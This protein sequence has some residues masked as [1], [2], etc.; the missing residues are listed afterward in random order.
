MHCYIFFMQQ[1]A[2]FPITDTLPMGFA[3]CEE[4]LSVAAEAKLL[5]IISALPFH[6]A[7]YKEWSAKRRVIHYGGRYDFNKQQLL[8]A[9]TLPDWMLEL[10]LKIAQW[11][12]VPAEHFKQAL[13]NEYQ[14][15][16]QLGWHRDA[17]EFETV[18]GVSLAG[19]ACL[20]FRP[21]PHV[22]DRSRKGQAKTK[23]FELRP[24]SIYLLQHAA[25]WDW[26]HAIAP[27][28][29]LRYSITFR[30]LRQ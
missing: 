7:E 17:P 15:G 19:D 23:V 21:Y 30:T 10:R 11:S 26:Q 20:R 12:A 27:T 1:A 9:D 8:T 29:S 5:Q 2:L 22:K 28:Q 6:E 25:R 24:R 14:P 3:H 18:V 13:I 4:F 16:V